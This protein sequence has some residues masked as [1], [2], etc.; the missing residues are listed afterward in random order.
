M[1]HQGQQCPDTGENSDH[2]QGVGPGEMGQRSCD[3]DHDQ[4]SHRS[5][6]AEQHQG[7]A[8]QPPTAG[9]AHGSFPSVNAP[10]PVQ[11]KPTQGKTDEPDADGQDH[12]ENR[13]CL[14]REHAL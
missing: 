6:Q 5:R 7:V 8:A 11:A 14:G 12:P 1:D 3:H 4:E 13:D 9:R 10:D 2:G